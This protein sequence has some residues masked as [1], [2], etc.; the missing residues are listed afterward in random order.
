MLKLKELVKY[1]LIGFFLY[2]CYKSW[3]KLEAK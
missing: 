1:A 3:L 2:F